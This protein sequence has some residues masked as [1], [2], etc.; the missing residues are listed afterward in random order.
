MNDCPE[1]VAMYRDPERRDQV[2]DPEDEYRRY[3][4]WLASEEGQAA[5]QA[6]RDERDQKYRE[7]FEGRLGREQD[8]WTK[9][10]VGT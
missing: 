2:I 3:R 1:V 4:A 9:Q 6:A 5:V 7:E 8:R 10:T